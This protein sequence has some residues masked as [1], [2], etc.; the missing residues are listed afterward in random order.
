MHNPRLVIIFLRIGIAAV[1]LYSAIASFMQP[2]SW[3][4]YI[5]AVFKGIFPE[6]M[7]V[8][9]FSLFTLALGIWILSGWKTFF[10]ASMAALTLLVII[11]ANYTQMDIL[12]RD[13][14]IFMASGALVVSSYPDKKA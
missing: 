6:Q 12:F 2:Y 9:G 1:F 7:L 13:F 8:M 5:P 3:I 11:A 4:G 10:A 14:A